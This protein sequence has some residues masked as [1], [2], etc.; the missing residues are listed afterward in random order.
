LITF[1]E[2]PHRSPE[3][4]SALTMRDRILR[5]PL[6]LTFTDSEIEA[7][8]ADWHLGG[9]DSKTD[10]L[11]ACVVLTPLE[12]GTAKMRQ[13]AVVESRRGEGIGQDLVRFAEEFALTQGVRSMVLHAREDV[14]PFY[15][16][17][18][19]TLEG[20]PFIEVTIPHRKLRRAL[21]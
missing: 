10:D 18:G 12:S 8:S 7:E 3:Y 14:V 15:E 13:V 5:A 11:I 16:K 1:R 17:L 2:I 6:G 4:E 20:P 21:G 19:Y 9:F